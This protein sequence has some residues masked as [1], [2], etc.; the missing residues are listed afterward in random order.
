[1]ALGGME[2][3]RDIGEMSGPRPGSWMNGVALYWG[4]GWGL[5]D[6]QVDL[7]TRLL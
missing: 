5:E 4:G 1:M 3:R 6:E 2:E 7:S